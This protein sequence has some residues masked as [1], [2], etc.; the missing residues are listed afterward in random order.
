M[1]T[2][3]KF[4][5]ISGAFAIALSVNTTSN[6]LEFNTLQTVPATDF[7][8][9]IT[10]HNFFPIMKGIEFT[11]IT[12]FVST[13]TLAYLFIQPKTGEWIYAHVEKDANGY[14]IRSQGTGFKEEMHSGNAIP[15]SMTIDKNMECGP[16]TVIAQASELEQKFTGTT[17]KNTIFSI[18]A[19][20]QHEMD[21]SWVIAEHKPNDTNC[22]LTMGD[23]FTLAAQDKLMQYRMGTFK[24]SAPAIAN[25]NSEQKLTE[26]TLPQPKP[27]AMP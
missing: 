1:N 2:K 18:Y 4:A 15:V 9:S 7:H 27:T 13:H 25:N 6:A 19:L 24:W 11:P 20:K 3:Q 26:P 17:D 10:S 16:D 12:L 21:G 22:E 23:D 14:Y 5:S 8:T